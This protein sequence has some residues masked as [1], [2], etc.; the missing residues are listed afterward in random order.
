MEWIMFTKHLQAYSVERAA[1]VIGELGLDGLDL[2][3]RPGGHV[4]PADA[5]ARLPGIF[6]MV[7]GKGLTVPLL[8]T[9]ITSADDPYA[10]TIFRLA[11]EGGVRYIKLGYWRYDGFGSMARQVDE[12]KRTL[13]GIEALAL[14]Y[15]VPAALHTHSGDFMTASGPVVAELL[16]DR[17]PEVLVAYADP[18]HLFAEGGL[19]GWKMSLDL[20]SPWIRLIAVKDMFWVPQPDREL[21]KMRWVAMNCPLNVGVVPWP[22]VFACLQEIGFDGVVS[23]HAEYQGEHS[24]RNLDT[25]QVIQ[26]TRADLEYLEGIVGRG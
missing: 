20:L 5:E 10:K 22:E 3:V 12:V 4:E 1:D 25:R 17:D 14:R 26:Q 16:R 7:E 6:E 23:L 11:A 15:G 8:T 9:A 19:S 24:W 21:G 2:T 18:R 13:D